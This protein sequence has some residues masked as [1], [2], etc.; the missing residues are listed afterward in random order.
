M[1]ACALL[2]VGGGL[3]ADDWHQWRGVDR[4][5]V[6]EESGIVDELPDQLE[7]T[8]RVPINMGYSGPA[9]ADGRVFVTDWAEDPQPGELGARARL[10]FR[11]GKGEM[12]LIET[13]T[14]RNPPYEFSATYEHEHMVN[15]MTNRF[16][17]LDA[18]TTRWEA[19]LDYTRFNGFMP[20]LMA[21][22][23]PGMFKFKRQTQKWLDQFK[24]FSESR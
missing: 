18:K 8:W 24:V 17:S 10:L 19:V 15:T 1:A 22:L 7:I 11:Q 23:M 14:V 13:I 20:R 21:T 9:V 5:G 6:W 12:E 3:S 16:T 4:L 2:L